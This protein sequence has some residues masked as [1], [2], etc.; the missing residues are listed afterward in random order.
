MV[1]GLPG[2]GAFPLS[3]NLG[4]HGG[5][6]LTAPMN[7]ETAE[8]VRSIADGIIV[9]KRSPTQRNNDD[10]RP[11]N[12][13]EGWTDDGCVVIRHQTDIGV[14]NDASKII[15]FS[16]YMHLSTVAAQIRT[17]AKVRRKDIL[18]QAGQIY[19]D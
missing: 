12:Y 15:F 10:K 2:D 7:R 18:G 6:H 1:E 14:G 9:F 13:R 3:F 17:G 19:G 11:L 5:A 4:W 16:I 8:P